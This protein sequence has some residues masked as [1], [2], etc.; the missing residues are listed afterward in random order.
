[1]GKHTTVYYPVGG[2][3]RRDGTVS[4][5]LGDQ[6]GSAS[7]VL[8]AGGA[9]TA[10]Q[11][12]TPFGEKRIL[13]ASLPTDRLFTGQQEMA[14]LGGIYNYNARFYSPKSLL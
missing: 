13:N 6:L 3:L 10:E 9:V 11:R 2:A 14:D 8:D 1:M 12:Y 7:V 5:V 4:Y